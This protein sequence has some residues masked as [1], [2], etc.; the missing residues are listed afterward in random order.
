ME[1]G[2][3][4]TSA[5]SLST[6]GCIPSGPMNLWASRL[7]KWSLTQSSLTKGRS[8]FRQAP[9]LT[10]RAWDFWGLALA[11]E[12]EAKKAF[13][14]SAFSAS[15]VTRAPTSFG[16]GLTFSLG[17]RLLLMYFSRLRGLKM[18]NK[19]IVHLA[20]D[21]CII[22]FCHFEDFCYSWGTENY[23]LLWMKAEIL[24]Q[25]VEFWGFFQ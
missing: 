18:E 2:S 23:S 19:N 13:S 3:A 1:S 7:L 11:L 12:T 21:F 4:M 6:R 25:F 14:N 22:L 10:S 8:S 9:S 20:F 24:L 15:S 5:S 16:S 17:F